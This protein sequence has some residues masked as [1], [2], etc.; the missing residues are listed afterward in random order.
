MPFGEGD[1]PPEATADEAA[2]TAAT[3]R[4]PDWHGR[5]P[6]RGASASVGQGICV[7]TL[8]VTSAPL[9]HPLT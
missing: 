2:R 9:S 4:A 3:A 6:R 7:G 1:S 5:V 8:T